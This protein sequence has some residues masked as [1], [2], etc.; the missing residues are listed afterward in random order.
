MLLDRDFSTPHFEASHT[1][2]LGAAPARFTLRGV[3]IEATGAE[4]FS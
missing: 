4:V 3:A 2:R 1:R